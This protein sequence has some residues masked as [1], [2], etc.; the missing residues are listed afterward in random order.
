MATT[1]IEVNKVLDY[2]PTSV[3]MVSVAT[4][5]QRNVM[6][7]TRFMSISAKPSIVAVA[8]A[9]SRFSHDLIKQAGEFVLNVTATDQTELAAKVGKTS[10]R[11]G[12][13]FVENDIPIR[14]GTKVESPLIDGCAINMECKLINALEMGDRTL[15]VGEVLALHVDEGKTPVAR[16]RNKYRL[17]GD[18]I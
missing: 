5:G 1:E 10:G 11:N 13:K 8:V 15:F 3:V 12:D 16:L 4:N 6:S 18:Q 17:L 9:S 14:Q 2:F 7:A